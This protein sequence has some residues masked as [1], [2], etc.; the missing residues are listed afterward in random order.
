MMKFIYLANTMVFNFLLK[1]R[2]SV[3]I[4]GFIQ[5]LLKIDFV[6]FPNNVM[7]HW[8]SVKTSDHWNTNFSKREKWGFE[9]LGTKGILAQQSGLG[10]RWLDS[11]FF[12]QKD[13]TVKW[14]DPPAPANWR[15]AS[16]SGW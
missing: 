3:L 6:L 14:Q 12:P 5:S 15:T 10:L 7:I 8:S 11:P 16:L 2:M 9:I 1:K 13:D 4:T